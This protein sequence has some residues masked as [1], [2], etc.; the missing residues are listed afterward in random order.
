M[1]KGVKYEPIIGTKVSSP[2]E[3]SGFANP[4]TGENEDFVV[5]YSVI[6]SYLFGCI[7]LCCQN[8]SVSLPPVSHSLPPS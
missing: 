6:K 8:P 7:S 5:S 3:I 4:E 1:N 2:R